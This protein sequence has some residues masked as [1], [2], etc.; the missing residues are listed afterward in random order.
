MKKW[1]RGIDCFTIQRKMIVLYLLFGIIPMIGISIYTY[2][3]NRDDVRIREK[4]EINR[5]LENAAHNVEAE[6]ENL[7][8]VLNLIY[9][10]KQIYHYL[11]KDYMDE[12]LRYHVE[13]RVSGM[14]LLYPEITG[15]SIYSS[16]PALS[17][18]S[19]YFFLLDKHALWYEDTV[20]GTGET[21]FWYA[22]KNDAADYEMMLLKELNLY[23]TEDAH[24]VLKLE[25]SEN[26][27]EELLN[28]QREDVMQFVLDKN[29]VIIEGDKKEW[30]S[31]NAKDLYDPERMSVTWGPVE[32]VG[33]MCALVD[34]EIVGR[35]IRR[36]ASRVFLLCLFLSTIAFMCIYKTIVILLKR[37]MECMEQGMAAVGC[38]DLSYRIPE[39]GTDEIGRIAKSINQMVE[40]LNLVIEKSYEKE[41]ALRKIKSDLLQ[42]QVTPHFLYN[43][44]SMISSMALK[45][46]NQKEAE[47]I[48]CLSDFYRITLN[49]GKEFLTVGEELQVMES[50]LKIQNARFGQMIKVEYT[51][52]PE[53][54]ECRMLKLLFQPMVENAIYHGREEEMDSLNIGIKI[55]HKADNLVFEIIDDGMGMKREQLY[56]LQESIQNDSGNFGLRNVNARIRNYYGDAYGLYVESEYG[57]GTRVTIEIPFI[58]K[59]GH[60]I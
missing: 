32:P 23:G 34:N 41:L 27:F 50:Y 16:N 38:G 19:K 2:T 58:S 33:W 13:D 18:N 22:K 60:T 56:E 26:I 29:G 49:Q 43:A 6:F 55:F 8:A 47:L 45:S 44:L 25:L 54:L 52:Q 40:E 31:K 17:R 37:R 35:E 3:V 10:D 57:F 14:M 4:T 1:W 39:M 11:N 12:D 51:V 5:A 46:G 42:E 15:I 9:V 7:F 53:V 59:S 20:N 28:N 48:Q 36:N 24:H 21:V 30:I